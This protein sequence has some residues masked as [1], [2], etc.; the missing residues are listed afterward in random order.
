MEPS[1]YIEELK[2]RA[3]KSRVYAKHQLVGLELAVLLADQEHKTL[4]IKLAKHLNHER[5]FR[6]AKEISKK[7]DV[8]NKG[9]YFM[10]LLT[11]NERKNLSRNG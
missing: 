5:L 11:A 1:G 10:T 7:K 2:K 9:A 6:L 8:K 4:Y 3:K